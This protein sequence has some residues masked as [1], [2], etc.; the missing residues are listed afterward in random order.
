MRTEGS[1]KALAFAVGV[2]MLFG[3]YFAYASYLS[4]ISGTLPFVQTISAKDGEDDSDEEKDEEEDDKEDEEKEQEKAEK[5]REK[6]AEKKKKEDEKKRE[7]AKK[8]AERAAKPT[9][10]GSSSGVKLRG[11]GTV[12]DDSLEDESEDDDY[13]NGVKVRG[14]GSIDDDAEENETD[15]DRIE[16]RSGKDERE[17]MYKDREKTLGRVNEKIA[18]AEKKILEKQAEGV[19]VTAALAELEKA[20]AKVAGI[21]A[22]FA[23]GETVDIKVLVKEVERLAHFSRGKVLKASEDVVK[24][25]EKVA[26]RIAQTKE[27]ITYLKAMGGDATSYESSLSE[28]ESAFADAKSKIALGGSDFLAGLTSLEIVERRVKSI[29]NSVE[30]ALLALGVSDEDEF[31]A[32]HDEDVEDASDDLVELAEAD[33]DHLSLKNLAETHKEEAMKVS[34]LVARLDDR[35]RVVRGLLGNDSDILNELENEVAIN[36][37]RILAMQTAVAEIE[38]ESLSDLMKE[39]IGDLKSENAKL[40]NFISAQSLETG[41]FGW[42]FKLF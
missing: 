22:A 24:D 5:E 38:D 14:D 35:N 26:K 2:F 18:Q 23:P 10:S 16:H 31:E 19:D 33:E 36:E 4:G 28:A 29:K 15:D 3:G 42:F 39:K 9:N 11:D 6:A 34:G 32:E 1:H 7:A 30:G 25:V 17:A 40:A 8:A 21:E 27:K 12:D 20:K 13:V 41:V 37:A